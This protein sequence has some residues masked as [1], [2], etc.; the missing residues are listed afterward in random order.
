MHRLDELLLSIV[1]VLYVHFVIVGGDGF[2]DFDGFDV[3]DGGCCY[4]GGWICGDVGNR[5]VMVFVVR[6]V[7]ASGSIVSNHV[8]LGDRNGGHHLYAT[9]ESV[10]AIP[11]QVA[12]HGLHFGHFGDVAFDAMFDLAAFEALQRTASIHSSHAI[13]PMAN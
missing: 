6:G 1:V 8:D 4:Y 9:T 13:H 7:M 3:V 2:A 5:D 10:L 11:S 12:V